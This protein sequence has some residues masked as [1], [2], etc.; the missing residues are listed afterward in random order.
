M[1]RQHQTFLRD[2]SMTKATATR[3]TPPTE[4][5][6]PQQLRSFFEGR[7]EGAT[8]QSNPAAPP[9]DGSR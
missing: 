2:K 9:A 6:P 4:D 8:T 7:V 1:Q 3:D 5:H